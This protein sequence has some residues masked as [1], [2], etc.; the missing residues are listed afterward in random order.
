MTFVVIP[1]CSSGPARIKAPP[2]DATR[3]AAEA[4]QRCD[5]DHNGTV[6]PV[7]AA[8]S[9][10]LGAAFEHIDTDHDGS[11]SVE[12]IAARMTSWVAGGVGIVTQ[13]LRVTFN[14]KPLAGGHVELVPEPYLAKWLKPAES[15]IAP[16]GICSPSL[17]P[18]DLPQ[19]LHRG[20]NC[21]F[22]TVRITHPELM[23]PARYNAESTL[24]IEVRPDPDLFNPPRL[25]LETRPEEG[26][27]SR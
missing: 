15:D 11:L 12:E 24:G 8:A 3:A 18:A 20:M 22:Y 9:P 21:G 6:S 7:E 2:I 1:G 4:V 26:R 17:P 14:G 19:G 5:R 13:P 25:A 16:N 27:G 23:V 10:G